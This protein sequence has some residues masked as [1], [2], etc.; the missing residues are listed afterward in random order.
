MVKVQLGDGVQFRVHVSLNQMEDAYEMAL[1]NDRLLQIES[2]GG[3]T[4]AVN[5]REILY[6][7]DEGE[8]RV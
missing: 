4:R 2:A 7:E 8:A 3:T 6:F 5:P 1:A